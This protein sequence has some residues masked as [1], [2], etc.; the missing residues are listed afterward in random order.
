MTAYFSPV[1]LLIN[2]ILIQS[3]KPQSGLLFKA[4]VLED[5]A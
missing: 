5:M 3:F 1:N 2:D 4:T